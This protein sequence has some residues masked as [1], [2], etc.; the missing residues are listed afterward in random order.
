[1][2]LVVARRLTNG[3]KLIL[4]DYSDTVLSKSVGILRDEGHNV[5]GHAV[6]ISGYSSVE[7]L[8]KTVAG[9]GTINAIVHTA[10]VSL[11]MA[12]AK[13]I[14]EVGL[15]GTA[16]II[17]AFEAVA[18]PGTSLICVSSMA[19]H[20]A[21]L[22]LDLEKHLTTASLVQLLHHKEIDFDS[23]GANQ[24]AYVVAKQGNNLR[25]QAA[26]HAWGS[27]SARVNAISPGIISTA[28]GLQE[29]QSTSDVRIR[30]MVE[31]S[32]AR[33]MGTPDDIA[34]VAAFLAGL[35]ASFITGTDILVDGVRYLH[36][37]GIVEG[38]RRIEEVDGRVKE[39][40]RTE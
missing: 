26:A 37:V 17:E 32:G 5:E 18:S 19:G 21:T 34:G 38:K 27:K 1:M 8:S 31:L 39:K 36:N 24:M 35:E 29:L 10:G 2:G 7:K 30:A 22:S 33:R 23:P 28:M 4:A 15:L 13:Q 9:A 25:V 40:K 14:Y 6:N 16:N 11:V 20:F 3:R 12:T